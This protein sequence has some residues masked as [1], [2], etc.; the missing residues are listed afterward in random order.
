[1]S[2]KLLITIA[3]SVE[4]PGILDVDDAL[5]QI[6]DCFDLLKHEEDIS[7]RIVSA[8]HNSPFHMQLEAYSFDYSEDIVRDVAK[9]AKYSFKDNIVALSGGVMPKEWSYGS[10]LQAATS[11]LKRAQ[12]GIGKFIIDF[13][14]EFPELNITPSMARE[15]YKK[16]SAGKIGRARKEIGMID[17]NIRH[18]SV[19]E[20]KPAIKIHDRLRKVDVWCIISENLKNTLR[21]NTWGDAWDNQRVKVKGIIHYDKNGSVKKVNV[22]DLNIVEKVKVELSTIQDANFTNG[23]TA[24]EYLNLLRGESE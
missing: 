5:S 16:V 14:D 9:K 15:A 19:H 10:K 8:S 12:N 22:S 17:G 13:C 2:E 24:H 21:K 23:M 3:P 6:K 1:M 7:W 4:H 11:I 20:K 18:V